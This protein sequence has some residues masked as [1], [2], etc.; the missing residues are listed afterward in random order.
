MS[1]NYRTGVRLCMHYKKFLRMCIDGHVCTLVLQDLSIGNIILKFHP[2]ESAIFMWHNII[3][4]MNTSVSYMFPLVNKEK[5][6]H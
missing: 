4:I 1:V 2:L 6:L 3:I 5:P